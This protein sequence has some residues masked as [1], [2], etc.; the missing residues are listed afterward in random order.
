MKKKII[1]IAVTIASA[2]AGAQTS[3]WETPEYY[4][5]RALDPIKAS[6]AYSRGYT[7]KGSTIAIIDSGISLT[8]QEFNNKIK[9]WKDYTGTGLTDNVG[10]GTHVAGIA[11]AARNG[12]GMEGVAFDAN[13]IIAKVTNTGAFSFSTAVNAIQWA[14]SNGAEVANLSASI[15]IPTNI[16]PTMVSPG[17]YKTTLTNTGN[18]IGATPAQMAAAMT[19][20]IVLVVAAGNDGKPY[21]GGPAQLATAVDSKGQLVLGGRMII[22]GNWN[23][24]N[25][26]MN[27]TSNQA[28]TLCATMVGNICK[29][30]YKTSDFYLLAPGTGIYST[31]PSAKAG[32]ATMT[33]TSMAAP[34]ISGGVAIIHQMWPQMT[35]GNIVKLLTVTA[36]KNLPGYDVNIMGQGLMD[37][38]KA[39]RPVGN[40]GIPTTGR[41]GSGIVISA[42][43]PVL[44]TGGTASTSKL[45]FM[46]VDEF[47]RDF[48]V[49]G[50]HLTA[51]ATPSNLTPTQMAMPYV[52]HNNFSQ[53]NRY[54]DHYT[55]RNG[56]IEF[57]L[58]KDN[59]FNQ[60]GENP[61]MA[62]FAVYKKYKDTNVRFSGG[63]FVENATWLGNS[64]SGLTNQ[65]TQSQSV[66]N[67]VGVGANQDVSENTNV[68]ANLQ[69]GI[70]MTKASSDVITKIAPVMSYSWTLGIEQKLSN[71]HR[72]GA[73]MYQPV[74]AYNA[75]ADVNIASGVDKD[76]NLIT[77]QTTNLAADIKERRLG[78]YY[79]F[80]EKRNTD[81]LTFVEY[82]QNFQGI[83]GMKDTVAG[84]TLKQS[85]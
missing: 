47:E 28:G 76:F 84:L 75:R 6:S 34:V 29:D 37:L 33:G 51:T 78:I 85:F 50:K 44:V 25:N 45:S 64:V 36:N 42:P 74:V 53:F 1:A 58:Y 38:E 61:S 7:G 80:Q 11:A 39:T 49:K 17:I 10:H 48:Y 16:N 46:V 15:S 8:S 72:I 12:V 24:Q 26:T 69:H 27:P 63:M 67:F 66:T 62:E 3:V 30:P 41:L 70:T 21:P 81:L 73:M 31:S 55:A 79:K 40:L 13:L 14:A 32:Y 71:K 68:Y 9:L 57:N 59:T 82:R 54:T 23:S 83:E 35:G 5:S 65:G 52:N 56:N 2:C 19:N 77:T 18:Y 4:R 20:D 43:K 22:A 60:F